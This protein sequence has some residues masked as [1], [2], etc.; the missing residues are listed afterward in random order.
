MDVLVDIVPE[1]L[2]CAVNA[3]Q[4]V[5]VG[6]VFVLVIHQ[7]AL[8][9]VRGVAISAVEAFVGVDCVICYNIIIPPWTT[10]PSG[11]TGR[12]R[13]TVRRRQSGRPD[14]SK[15]PGALY[16]EERPGH[17]RPL[18]LRNSR[19]P[20]SRLLHSRCLFSIFTPV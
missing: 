15:R 9:D 3:V 4:L 13:R 20:R 14:A 1:V 7:D 10:N 8:F 2:G 19:C 16:R 5:V 11:M 17:K 12:G 6:V 18:P